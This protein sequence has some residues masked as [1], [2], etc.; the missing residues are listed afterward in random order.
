MLHKITVLLIMIAVPLLIIACGN[1]GPKIETEA[2]AIDYIQNHLR[3]TTSIDPFPTVSAEWGFPNQY[4]G[5]N[6]W[7][8]WCKGCWL[9]IGHIPRVLCEAFTEIWC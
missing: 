7:D 8:R 3:T 4:E 9:G 1:A 5:E 2:E 6:C